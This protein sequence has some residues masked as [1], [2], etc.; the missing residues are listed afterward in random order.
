MSELNEE[1]WAVISERGDEARGLKH[2]D[3][4]RL[5]R[6]LAGESVRGLCV[7]TNDAAARLRGDVPS[8]TNGDRTAAAKPA[9]KRRAPKKKTAAATPSQTT[10]NET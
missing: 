10:F 8:A 4:V 7:V 1:R 3:A 9:R 6:R 2:G 5:L